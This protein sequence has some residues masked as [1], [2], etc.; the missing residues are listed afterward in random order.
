MKLQYAMDLCGVEAAVDTLRMLGDAVDIAEVGTPMLLKF[1]LDAVRRVRA[2]FPA[3]TLLADA[4]IIDAGEL[5]AALAFDAGADIVTVMGTTNES[6]IRGVI[7]CARGRGK[8]SFIDTMCVEPIEEAC[9][10]YAAWGA[11]YICI[12]NAT[13]LL[14]I[15]ATLALAKRA[16]TAIEPERLVIA[17]GVNERTAHKLQAYAPGI[18]VVG[19]A[20]AKSADPRA[21]ALR[22]RDLAAGSGI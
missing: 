3:L 1:G 11:D 9:G 12:H 10:R 17:G 5:E 2:A 19:S 16:L 21:T 18:V 20:I 14:D 4:K 6:T 8:K 15:D 7:D 13:D 22:L